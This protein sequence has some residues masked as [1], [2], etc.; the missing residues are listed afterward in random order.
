MSETVVRNFSQS[1]PAQLSKI[2]DALHLTLSDEMLA[3]CARHYQAVERRAPFEDELVALSALSAELE[4]LSD[5]DC[6][7]DFSTADAEIAATYADAIEK[8][9]LIHP[10]ASYPPTLAE[11]ATLPTRELCRVGVKLPHQEVHAQPAPDTLLEDGTAALTTASGRVH[12]R[13]DTPASHD[14]VL[15]LLVPTASGGGELLSPVPIK[16]SLRLDRVGILCTLLGHFDGIAID[17]G[18]FASE[19]SPASVTVLTGDAYRG[20]YLLCVAK[21]DVPA[22]L[23]FMKQQKIHGFPFARLTDTHTVSFRHPQRGIFSLQ[24]SFLRSLYRRKRNTL[25]IDEER[26][27]PCVPIEHAPIAAD[28]CAYLDRASML[29]KKPQVAFAGSTACAAASATLADAPFRGA[30]YTALVPILTQVAYGTPIHCQSLSVPLTYPDVGTAL[31]ALLGL[32]RLQTELGVPAHEHT[33][34][35]AAKDATAT[36][37][38]FSLS[39]AFPLPSRLSSPDATVY[40]HPIETEENG[41]P[42]FS[43]LRETLSLLTDLSEKH[44]IRSVRVLVNETVEDG[45][46]KMCGEHVYQPTEELARFASALPLG[47]LIESNAAITLD[48]VATTVER[49]ECKE[50]ESPAIPSFSESLIPSDRPEIVLLANHN[51]ED[52][53]FLSYELRTRGARVHRFSPSDEDL[54]PLTRALLGSH[55]L[56]LCQNVSLP[57]DAYLRFALDTMR[58][59]GGSVLALYESGDETVISLPNGIPEGLLSSFLKKS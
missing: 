7:Y 42:R 51:D 34:I 27:V 47:I 26:L 37:S 18:A 40:C 19:H 36:L 32:Y 57:E 24:A 59:A 31:S 49:S 45:L 28:T 39:D 43:S 53:R 9:K 50:K 14:D 35:P 11:L 2:K 41:L 52:A 38:V 10:R 3:Y 46:S 20:A 25:R 6:I 4:R 8:R 56:I 22:L 29:G 15:L 21:A 58:R 54:G 23:H 1:S 13:P 12:L 30:L 48:A 5:A 55:A 33:L 16:R 44:L 17:L